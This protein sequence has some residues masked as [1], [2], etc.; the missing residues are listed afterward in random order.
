MDLEN[1]FYNIEMPVL[2]VLIEMEY[3]G[4]FIDEKLMVN[5]LFKNL[6]EKV[7]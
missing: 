2:K 5:K 4:V 1:L 3:N 6:K 7:R